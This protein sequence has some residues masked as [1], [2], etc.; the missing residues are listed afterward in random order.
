MDDENDSAIS[1]KFLRSYKKDN[2]ALH[3]DT[4]DHF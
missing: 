2:F 1:A 3:L 4:K